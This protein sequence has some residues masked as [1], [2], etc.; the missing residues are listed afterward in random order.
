MKENFYF[1]NVF[2]GTVERLWS[3]RCFPSLGGSTNANEGKEQ[4]IYI[5]ISVSFM[6]VLA[7][8]SMKLRKLWGS[9]TKHHKDFSRHVC[10]SLGKLLF[11]PP[12]IIYNV[13]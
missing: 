8:D 5:Y 6:T 1:L 3:I 2:C 13:E 12:R 7:T 10:M 9:T 4:D 11:W